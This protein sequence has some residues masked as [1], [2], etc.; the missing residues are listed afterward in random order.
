MLVVGSLIVAY[1]KKISLGTALITPPRGPA[2]SYYYCWTFVNL[3]SPHPGE[4]KNWSGYL[5][6]LWAKVKFDSWGCDFIEKAATK[7]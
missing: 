4:E 6:R 2:A 1:Y 3:C 7:K 5:V